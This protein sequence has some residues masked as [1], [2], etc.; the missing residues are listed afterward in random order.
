MCNTSYADEEDMEHLKKDIEITEEY[1][2]ARNDSLAQARTQRMAQDIGNDASLHGKSQAFDKRRIA[3][4]FLT[5]P[6]VSIGTQIMKRLGWRNGQGVGPRKKRKKEDDFHAQGHL[7]AP[8]EN[9]QQE[10]IVAKRSLFGVGFDPVCIFLI[11][12]HRSRMH[13]NL[14]PMLPLLQSPLHPCR[15]QSVLEE[16]FS[17]S[18]AVALAREYLT[19]KMTMSLMVVYLFF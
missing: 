12:C 18:K 15:S 5:T 7:F 14:L 9:S 8:K 17:E 2:T 10:K 19:M 16:V 1:D 4:L 11:V 6:A 3:E 13:L